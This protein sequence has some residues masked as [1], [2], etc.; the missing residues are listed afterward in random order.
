[1]KRLVVS[2]VI[3]GSCLFTGCI[4]IRSDVSFEPSDPA[5]ASAQASK[6][7]PG[8]TTVDELVLLLGDP[9]HRQ[10]DADGMESWSYRY[11]RISD[12][13]F[14][15]CPFITIKDKKESLL[16]LQFEIEDGVVAASRRKTSE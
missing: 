3:L 14:A 4:S 6:V 7:R 5:V 12:G 2:V 15:L 11:Q 10:A 16:V 13:H 9:T 8:K 1:M